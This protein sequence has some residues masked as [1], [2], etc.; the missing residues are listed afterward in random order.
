M[1]RKNYSE[2]KALD[3]LVEACTAGRLDQIAAKNAEFVKA[4]KEYAK[5]A[6]KM[7]QIGLSKEQRSVIIDMNDA[8]AAQ[9]A[10]Y[11]EIA[12]KQGLIDALDLLEQAK[13]EKES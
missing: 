13:E 6:K 8:L 12:Y 11:A 5:A 1:K 4:D 3:F 7:D 9:S 10:V 2:M